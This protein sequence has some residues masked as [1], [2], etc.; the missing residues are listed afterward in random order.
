MKKSG[1]P[2]NCKVISGETKSHSISTDNNTAHGLLSVFIFRIC[3]SFKV[4]KT[5][6]KD[7][8]ESC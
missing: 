7:P 2:K 1:I 3:Y 5:V 8:G 6:V 4:D